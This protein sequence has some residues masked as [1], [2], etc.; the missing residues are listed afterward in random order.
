V[1]VP[2]ASRLKPVLRNCGMK[3]MAGERDHRTLLQGA[4]LKGST[5]LLFLLPRRFTLVD[6]LIR[7]LRQAVNISGQQ[8]YFV[9]A[10]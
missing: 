4:A 10:Q 9:I 2:T 6:E 7:T 1:N 3:E 8:L 5:V